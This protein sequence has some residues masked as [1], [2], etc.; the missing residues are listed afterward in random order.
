MLTLAGNEGE[1]EPI[2]PAHLPDVLE[3]LAQPGAASSQPMPKSR[4][5]S[6]ASMKFRFTP[7]A[8]QNIAAIADTL[9]TRHSDVTTRMRDAT[10]LSAESISSL[11]EAGDRLESWHWMSGWRLNAPRPCAD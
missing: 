2:D 1:P 8:I 11:E 9:S 7:R 10:A 3:S 6:A 5:H 4:P